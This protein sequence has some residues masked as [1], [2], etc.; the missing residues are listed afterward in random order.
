MALQAIAKNAIDIYLDE[1]GGAPNFLDEWWVSSWHY[2]GTP[3][4]FEDYIE[5]CKA[6][7]RTR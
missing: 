5:S 4:T 1:F 7:W 6:E 2:Y 3:A